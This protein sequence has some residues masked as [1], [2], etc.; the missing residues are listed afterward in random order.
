MLGSGGGRRVGSFVAAAV[1]VAGMFVISGCV[2]APPPMIGTATPGNGIATLTWRP[3]VAAPSPI[4]GYV[5]R[6]W[7]GQ[8][9]QAEVQF[10]SASTTQTVIGLSNGTTYTFTVVGVDALGNTTASSAQ[11][12]AVT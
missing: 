8:A 6:P 12:N 1:L 10:N 9:P 3:P 4:T 7:V 5:V 11:S 2:A